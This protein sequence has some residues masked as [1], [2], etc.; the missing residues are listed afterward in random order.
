MRALKVDAANRTITEIDIPSGM[1]LER[2]YA[3]IGC[4]TVEVVIDIPVSGKDDC[5]DSVYVDEEGWLK[6]APHWFCIEGGH[7]PFAGSAVVVGTD[8]EGD[9]CPATISLERLTSMVTFKSL[10]EIQ[11]ELLKVEME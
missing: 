10:G 3:E 9:T 7:Q 2:A 6:P 4:N 8:E 11:A 1:F 5:Y